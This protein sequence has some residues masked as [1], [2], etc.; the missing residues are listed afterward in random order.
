MNLRVQ[1][2]KCTLWQ[3]LIKNFMLNTKFVFYLI[4]IYTFMHG[5]KFNLQGLN[6]CIQVRYFI[7]NYTLLTSLEILLITDKNNFIDK[8]N[9][10]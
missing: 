10:E 2:F 4:H 1:F 3:F 9:V 8:F 5:L 7:N 6:N